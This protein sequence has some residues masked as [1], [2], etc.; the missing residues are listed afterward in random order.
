MGH[1][2]TKNDHWVTE[3]GI[4]SF[5]N[6]TI[7]ESLQQCIA[8]LYNNH[9]YLVDGELSQFPKLGKKVTRPECVTNKL[10][11][12]MRPLEPFKNN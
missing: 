12:E 3:F 2:S 5:Q 10:L 1:K 4:K 7:N 11:I 9:L 8:I 6:D